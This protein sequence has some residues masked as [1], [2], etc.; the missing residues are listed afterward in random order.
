MGIL[1]KTLKVE[2]LQNCFVIEDFG[3]SRTGIALGN[4]GRLLVLK[5]RR[6]FILDG[7]LVQNVANIL[8]INAFMANL[9]FGNG[10]FQY[11]SKTKSSD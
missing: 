11:C 5:V 9:T 3:S 7:L 10:R 4:A 1:G 8:S 6:D 2:L